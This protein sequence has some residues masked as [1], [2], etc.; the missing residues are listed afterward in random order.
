ME[1][2]IRSLPDLWPSQL[3][4]RPWA[5]SA[6][7]LNRRD[8]E[9]T[10]LGRNAVW[11]AVKL[12][13]LEGAEVIAPAYHHGVEIEA[14]RAAGARVRFARV[15]AA[16]RLDVEHVESQL[17]PE[18]RALYVIHYAGFPQPMEPLVR[19]ARRHGLR[20][21]EDCAL[22]LFSRDGERPLGSQGD[23]AIF[24]FYKTVPVPHGGALLLNAPYVPGPLPALRPPPLLPTLSHLA[25]SLLLGL[26]REL[27]MPGRL[28]RSTLK[29]VTRGLRH[30]ADAEDV[31]VGTQQFDPAAVDLG[32]SPLTERVLRAAPAEEIVR[33]RRAHWRFLREGLGDARCSPW[34]ELPPGVCPLFFA[35]R[36]DDKDEALATLRARGVEA[37]DF[38]RYGHPSVERGR[39]PEVEHLRRHILE[40][41]CHQDLTPRQLERLVRVAREV[42]GG[43][44]ERKEGRA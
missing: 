23:A 15:D 32:M 38:W 8:L 6:F 37:V 18:T 27:G 20:I 40:L 30:R 26:E 19:L 21:I 12:L 25:G 17:R 22:A 33:R 16:M 3:L 7:P 31:A 14:L 28:A 2:V 1:A 39:F 35:L 41:P 34:E 4:P 29:T 24:C 13:G 44:R 36:V 43:A 11:R 42:M 10:Y 9:L 5:H